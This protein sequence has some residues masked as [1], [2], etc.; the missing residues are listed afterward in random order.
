MKASEIG[1][2]E[3]YLDRVATLVVGTAAG[4]RKFTELAAEAVYWAMQDKSHFEAN[5]LIHKWA[6]IR[7]RDIPRLRAWFAE[8]GPFT[9]AE[10]RKITVGGDEVTVKNAVKYS[11]KAHQTNLGG[12][13]P[14]EAFGRLSSVITI[15]QWSKRREEPKPVTQDYIT[16]AFERL[17]KKAREN[18]LRLPVQPVQM[19]KPDSL[20][21]AVRSL[22]ES[23]QGKQELDKT[24]RDLLA[25]LIVALTEAET[26]AAA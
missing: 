6:S 5:A 1:N 23:A 26:E 20:V 10:N 7:P 11:E 3:E 15:S 2:R 16:K 24:Q 21:D 9:L 4:D 12:L 25:K 18:G 8:F 19:P 22:V 17:E 13:T 14:D